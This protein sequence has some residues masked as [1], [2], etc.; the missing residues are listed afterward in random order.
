MQKTEYPVSM[1]SYY[2]IK[3]ANCSSDLYKHVSCKRSLKSEPGITAF[4]LIR[5]GKKQ[6]TA[7]EQTTALRHTHTPSPSI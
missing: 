3:A 1:A 6:D 2:K 4:P 7:H 5:A